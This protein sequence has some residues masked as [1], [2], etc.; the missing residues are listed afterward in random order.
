MKYF[1]ILKIIYI[2]NKFK[3]YKFNFILNVYKLNII[4][5]K[6]ILKKILIKKNIYKYI[7]IK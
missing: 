1:E 6:Y 7:K 4:L 5:Y 2:K 3:K